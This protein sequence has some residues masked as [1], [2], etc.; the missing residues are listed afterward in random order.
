MGTVEVNLGQHLLIKQEEDIGT[1]MELDV[2]ACVCS[3]L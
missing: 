3:C 1:Y 2:M